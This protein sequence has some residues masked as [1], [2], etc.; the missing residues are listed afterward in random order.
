MQFQS[1]QYVFEEGDVLDRIYEKGWSDGMPVVPPT[2][3]K[4][5]AMLK[6]AALSPDTILGVIPQR[7]RRITAEKVA[8]NAVMAGC[9]PSYMPIIVAAIQAMTQMPFNLHGA[10]ASTAGTAFL[11]VVNGPITETLGVQSGKNALGSNS[12]NRVNL[13][14]GRALRLIMLNVVGSNEYDQST[15]GHPGKISMCLAEEEV[16]GWD[17]LHIE[18]GFSPEQSTVTV[19]AAE[20]PNQ[21]NNHLSMEAEGMLHSFADRMSAWGTYNLVGSTQ[22]ALI[23]CKEHYLSLHREGWNKSA[24]KSFLF[25]HAIRKAAELMEKKILPSTFEQKILTVVDKPEDILI[26]TAGGDAG[27]FSAF[28]PGWGTLNATRAVTQEI[29]PGG[30]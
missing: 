4:V 3:S 19:M 8:I 21:I 9:L 24:I 12:A 30:T 1:K 26:I 25:E 7:N 5:E 16:E 2:P 27:R 11:L 29:V 22:C 23:I 28:I 6:E 17:P 14:I 10:S 20:G 18:R 13:T 15:L